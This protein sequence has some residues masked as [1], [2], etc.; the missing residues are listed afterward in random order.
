[1]KEKKWWKSDLTLQPKPSD[2][3]TGVL[4]AGLRLASLWMVSDQTLFLLK[5]ACGVWGLSS[6][7]KK[8]VT[9]RIHHI[10]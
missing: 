10:P 1:M 8:N 3:E 9:S 4:P 5:L 6:M 7:D 2:S